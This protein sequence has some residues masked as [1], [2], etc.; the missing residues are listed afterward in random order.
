MIPYHV[1]GTSR[2]YRDNEH[3][4]C[5][6]C[7]QGLFSNGNSPA[8]SVITKIASSSSMSEEE[9]GFIRGASCEYTPICVSDLCTT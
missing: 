1:G 8:T 2:P 5:I 3:S 6:A 9:C 7:G 4:V